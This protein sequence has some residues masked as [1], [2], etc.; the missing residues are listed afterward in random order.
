MNAPMTVEGLRTQIERCRLL[1]R[2]ADES[3]AQSLLN[4]ADSYEQQLGLIV[5]PQDAVLRPNQ[6][7][8]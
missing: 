8:G 1:A 7:L 3:T 6:I 5:K 4:M 2:A